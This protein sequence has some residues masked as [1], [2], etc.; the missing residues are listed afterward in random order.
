[1]HEGMDKEMQEIYEGMD[2]VIDEEMYKG[3]DE[4]MHE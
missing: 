4:E 3:I 1:M 2:E